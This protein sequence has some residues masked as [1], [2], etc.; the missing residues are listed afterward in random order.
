MRA[1]RGMGAVSKAKRPR[2]KTL[3]RKDGDVFSDNGVAKRRKDG[4]T[5]TLFAA[6][7]KVGK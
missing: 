6:G 3:R 7:G 4:D 2:G 5:F 1:S